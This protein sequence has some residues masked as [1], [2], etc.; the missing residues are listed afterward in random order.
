MKSLVIKDTL[1][2]FPDSNRQFLIET[3]ASN[4]QLGAVI[5]QCNDKLQQNMS[6]AFYSQKLTPTQQN[7][8]TIEKELLTIVEVF[9]EFHQMLLGSKLIV[10]TDHKNLTHHMTH[11]M[12]QH[13]FCW[14]LLLEEFN[15]KFE[16]LTV[17]C[18]VIAYALS[19]VPI[20]KGNSQSVEE[21]NT[22][23][24][25][26]YMQI[27]DQVKDLLAKPKHNT[28]K[29][30]VKDLLV[31]PKHEMLTDYPIPTN[32]IQMGQVEDLLVKP[33]HEMLTAEGCMVGSHQIP[34]DKYQESLLYYP[35][36]NNQLGYCDFPTIECYQSE[37]L[38]LQQS[39]TTNPHIFHMHVGNSSLICTND[40]TGNWKIVLMDTL[41]LKIIQWSHEF[42]MHSEGAEKLYKMI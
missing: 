21:I 28:L 16:Y 35:V 15:P 18:N 17:K 37:D 39:L 24:V 25:E 11:F 26:L 38:L 33:K 3:D 10:Y 29:G 13:I 31:K 7:Y 6:I 30:Q 8:T 19:C 42:L 9:K 4:Y 41:M 5:K 14:Q 36:F 23:C 20:D 32:T 40:S 2:V 1:L 22:N 34:K 12:T 27:S